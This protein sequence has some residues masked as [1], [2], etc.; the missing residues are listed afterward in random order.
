VKR[1]AV[2]RLYWWREVLITL[3][4]YQVYSAIRNVSEGTKA[5]A[6]RHAQQLMDWQAAIGI[7]HEE[8]LQSWALNS[9]PLIV[10]MN[11]IYGSLHFIVTAGVVIYLYRRWPGDYPRWRNTLALTTILALIGFIFW[12]LMPPR[13]LHTA[14]QP[15][16]YEFVDTLAKYPTFWSFES[17][18][19]NKISNQYAA[20]PSLHFGWSLFCAAA[21][22]PRVRRRP[23]RVAAA[24]YPLLTLTAIVLTGN[25]FFLDAAG[26]AAVFL[27]GYWLARR[28]TR[29]GPVLTDPETPDAA[30]GEAYSASPSGSARFTE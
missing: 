24:M 19:I 7:N 10:F 4:L 28:F 16:Q 14:S 13:L 9:R 15:G 12:P 3:I 1:P 5:E 6:Y 26:G 30:E 8:T 29:P 11:Y 23:A 25:H 21:L 18:A 2:R 27:A 22:A 20:M 17:G